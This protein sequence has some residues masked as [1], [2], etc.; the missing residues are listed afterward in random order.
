MTERSN[1]SNRADQIDPNADLDNAGGPPL[2]IYTAIQDQAIASGNEASV[3]N[4]VTKNLSPR[5][6]AMV[7]SS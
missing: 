4:T 2:P 6:I 3:V 5:E 1:K 7:S